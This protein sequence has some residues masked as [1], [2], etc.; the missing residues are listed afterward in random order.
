MSGYEYIDGARF[1]IKAWIKGVP[2]EDEAIQQLRNTADLPFVFKHLSVM[3][4]A[5]FGRGCCIGSV[6]PTRGA[7]IPAAVG[8]D[9]GCFTADTRVMLADGGTPTFTELI[10][11]DR[12]GVELYGYGYCEN[13]GICGKT[14]LYSPRRTRTTLEIAEIRCRTFARA[15]DD[16]DGSTAFRYNTIVIRCTPDHIF[17]RSDAGD[18]PGSYPGVKAEHLKSGDRLFGMQ[19][20]DDGCGAIHANPDGWSWGVEDVRIISHA[21]PVDVYCLTCPEYGTFAVAD[22]ATDT[23]V[24][25][26]NCGMNAV[27]QS[28]NGNDICQIMNT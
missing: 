22:P 27:R 14:R 28:R 9:L 15:E 7:I 10:E 8:V 24:F 1:P 21:E 25:V 20:L 16:G 4:D 6:I 2:V 5:H 26:H 12:D 17:Y 11:M 19:L 23:A 18:I 13:T 3:P